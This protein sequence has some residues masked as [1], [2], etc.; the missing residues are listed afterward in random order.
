MHT[1]NKV[2][3]LKR[4]EFHIGQ[5]ESM[6]NFWGINPG[7]SWDRVRFR[8]IR[9][10]DDECMVEALFSIGYA[11]TTALK[12]VFRD[13]VNR[14]V[15]LYSI[16]R[17]DLLLEQA[18]DFTVSYDCTSPWKEDFQERASLRVGKFDFLSGGIRTAHRLRRAKEQLRSR[19]I[20]QQVT[21]LQ[22]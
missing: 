20:C 6:A 17:Q 14:A 11:P 16:D 4:S 3:K 12:R 5:E 8:S 1:P 10:L 9:N 2:M 13:K 22:M 21:Y 7:V 18:L 19:R 15:A